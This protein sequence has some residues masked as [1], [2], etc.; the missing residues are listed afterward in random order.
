MSSNELG[1]SACA[2]SPAHAASAPG[3]RVK[4][5]PAAAPRMNSRRFRYTPSGVISDDGMMSDARRI[6]MEPL[7]AWPRKL[8]FGRIKHGPLLNELPA[9]L[10]P[11]QVLATDQ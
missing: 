5:A 1:S 3:T 4:A 11:L 8:T 9:G 6:S 7:G 2:L 10:V